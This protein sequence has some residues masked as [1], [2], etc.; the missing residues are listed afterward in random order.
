MIRYGCLL[1]TWLSCSHSALAQVK[2]VESAWRIYCFAS[3]A[4]N[5]W[6]NATPENFEGAIRSKSFHHE[7]DEHGEGIRWGLAQWVEIHNPPRQRD[8][9]DFPGRFEFRATS[10]VLVF[11]E[12]WTYEK[13]GKG[14]LR[15]KEWVRRTVADLVAGG[16]NKEDP[17]IRYGVERNSRSKS[18]FKDV[19]FAAHAHANHGEACPIVWK[20]KTIAWVKSG[21][22]ARGNMFE[23]EY[24][25]FWSNQHLVPA[26]GGKRIVPML[27]S[28]S[29]YLNWSFTVRPSADGIDPDRGIP[30]R[31]PNF[32]IPPKDEV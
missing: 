21:W 20:G 13:D 22:T 10:H 27:A 15:K 11:R 31:R 28:G 25:C 18:G 17:A 19:P 26:K 16:P 4:P 12:F 30:D 29:I 7:V 32:V 3:P 6:K 8:V 9:V 24:G 2:E 5:T 1:A 23:A 14:V